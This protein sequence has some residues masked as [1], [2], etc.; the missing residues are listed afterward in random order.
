MKQ[1]IWSYLIR[2]S[3]DVLNKIKVLES[4]HINKKKIITFNV[5]ILRD[6]DKGADF[7]QAQDP[8]HLI[9]KIQNRQGVFKKYFDRDYSPHEIL[10]WKIYNLFL[11]TKTHQGGWQSCQFS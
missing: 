3:L 9:S 10:S 7:I 8:Q 11:S 5:N 6:K 2:Y 4:F 1:L